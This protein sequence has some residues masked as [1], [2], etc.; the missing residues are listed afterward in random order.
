MNN[1]YVTISY[2]CE[3]KKY[4]L[5]YHANIVEDKNPFSNG[6]PLGWPFDSYEEASDFLLTVNEVFRLSELGY[7]QSIYTELFVKITNDE[8]DY[9]CIIEYLEKEIDDLDKIV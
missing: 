4:F 8:I 5:V 1:Q 2:S 9:D 6:I 7:K 3:T